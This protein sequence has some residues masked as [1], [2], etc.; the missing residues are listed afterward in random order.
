MILENR[1]HPLISKNS[2]ASAM[3][4]HYGIDTSVFVRLLTGHPE[5]EYEKTVKRFEARLAADPQAEFFVSNQVIGDSYIALQHHYGTE[6]TAA[7]LAMLSVL[8]SG[9]CSP[10]NGASVLDA[11]KTDKGCGLLGRLIAD[12]YAARGMKVLTND[13]R[14]GRL[15]SAEKI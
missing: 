8:T 12:D 4:H 11:L 15:S 1:F 3:T 10:L 13:R 6:K 5:Q 7:K 14:M 9:L 2:A